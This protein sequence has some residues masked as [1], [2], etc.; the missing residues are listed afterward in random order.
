MSRVPTGSNT[1]TIEVANMLLVAR[2]L[3]LLHIPEVQLIRGRA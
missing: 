3:F 2:D 1:R